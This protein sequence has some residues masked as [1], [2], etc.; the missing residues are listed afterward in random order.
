MGMYRDFGASL[1]GPVSPL[2][3][4]VFVLL[5]IILALYPISLFKQQPRPP[6]SSA[7]TRFVERSPSGLQI[8]PASCP[9]SPDYDGQCSG[10]PPPEPSGPCAIYANPTE[11]SQGESTTLTWGVGDSVVDTQLDALLCAWGDCR[12]NPSEPPTGVSLMYSDFGSGT[13]A[14][15]AVSQTGSRVVSPTM[16]TTYTIL[17]TYNWPRPPVVTCRRSITVSQCPAQQHWVTGDRD[18][19]L[20]VFKTD[21]DQWAGFTGCVCD[22][23]GVPPLAHGQCG[24]SPPPPTGQCTPSNVCGSPTTVNNSCTGTLVED[25]SLRGAGWVCSAGACIPGTPELSISASPSLLRSGDTSNVT[26]NALR[27]SSCTVTENSG[28]ISD[29]WSCTSSAACAADHVNATSG[30]VEQTTYTLSCTAPG[31]VTLTKSAIVNIIPIFQE[32]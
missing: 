5:A 14:N 27:V 7:E 22:T 24:N 12:S 18:P 1:R 9:S 25:C 28:H 26:W 15:D 8:V 13:F 19:A 11:V 17:A 10:A 20:A 32:L 3:K 31:G 29:F 2:E 21:P 30:I 16:P 23:T 6:I 4:T